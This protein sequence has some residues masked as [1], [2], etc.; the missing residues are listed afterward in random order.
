M[1][2]PSSGQSANAAGIASD[3]QWISRTEPGIV[4]GARLPPIGGG[5]DHW[6]TANMGMIGVGEIV[7][8]ANHRRSA[9]AIT[10]CAVWVI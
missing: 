8:P 5:V 10:S 6:V 2:L 9:Q 7:D 1:V 4:T 3:P